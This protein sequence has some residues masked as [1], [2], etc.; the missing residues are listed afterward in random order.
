MIFPC[1]TSAFLMQLVTKRC[2]MFLNFMEI[3]PDS[4]FYS[5]VDDRKD[6]RSSLASESQLLYFDD[7]ILVF[8]KPPNILSAPGLKDHY[9]LATCVSKNYSIERVDHMIAHRLDY[10]TSGVIIYSRNELSLK[11]L[12]KQFREKTL[13][14]RYSSIMAGLPKSLEGEIDL[15]LGRDPDIGPPYY[16][17]DSIQGKKSLTHWTVIRQGRNS[18]YVHLRPLTGRTHQLRILMAAI[19]H[20]LLG[21]FLYAPIDIYYASPRLQLHAEYLGIYHPTTGK[22]MLFHA[23]CPLLSMMDLT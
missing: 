10:A 12:H 19:G 21:D 7:D 18:T 11:K 20:P 16:R 4:A 22:P 17:V 15:P 1:L 3:E 23:P 9:N 14:K 8:N 6:Q 13:Y 5:K 2:P